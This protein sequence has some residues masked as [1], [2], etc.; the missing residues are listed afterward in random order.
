MNSLY[1]IEIKNLELLAS[2]GILPAERQGRQRILISVS[3]QAPAKAALEANS[4]AQLVSYAEIVTAIETLVTQNHID[5]V[6]QLAREILKLCF[7]HPT[8]SA[9]EVEVKKPEI[10]PNAESVGC[11]FR[12]SREEFHGL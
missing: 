11:R 3:L 12:L 9:A 1:H 7:N 10:I 8:I 2:I 4:I 5:L 6:E